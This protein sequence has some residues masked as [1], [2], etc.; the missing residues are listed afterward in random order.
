[1]SC[2]KNKE[3]TKVQSKKIPTLRALRQEARLHEKI[4]AVPYMLQGACLERADT[5]HQKKKLV[6]NGGVIHPQKSRLI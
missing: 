5:G 2:R 6:I 3:R 4:Q 1:M